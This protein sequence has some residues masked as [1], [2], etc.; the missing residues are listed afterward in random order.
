MLN[1]TS[2]DNPARIVLEAFDRLVEDCGAQSAG[3]RDD[4]A[5]RVIIAA[6][7]DRLTT[8]EELMER[9]MQV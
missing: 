5:R 8:T 2:D 9:A 3:L 4:L 7:R 1:E 6:T